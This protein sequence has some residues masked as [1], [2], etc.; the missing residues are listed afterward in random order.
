MHKYIIHSVNPDDAAS[1]ILKVIVYPVLIVNIIFIASN[2]KN[3]IAVYLCMSIEFVVHI[4]LNYICERVGWSNAKSLWIGSFRNVMITVNQIIVEYYSEKSAPT[5]LWHYSNVLSMSILY[6]VWERPVWILSVGFFK[7]TSAFGILYFVGGYPLF[8]VVSKI[9]I[10][11][12]ISLITNIM[13]YSY[14]MNQNYLKTIHVH[15]RDQNEHLKSLLSSISDFLFR[16]DKNFNIE[17]MKSDFMN[18]KAINFIGKPL[19][20]IINDKE[21]IEKSKM[22]LENV[23]STAEPASWTW[24]YQYETG[25]KRFFSAR[26]SA[27]IKDGKVVSVT[28]LSSDITDKITAEE[29]AAEA[30]RLEISS[31]AK[32]EFIS[33][34]RYMANLLF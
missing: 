3:T 17:F 5:W 31:K 26:A 15:I 7:L 10:L 19:W 24:V 33:A 21:S 9:W 6:D 23:F 13:L 22:K 18:K 16:I 34:V 29:R 4:I 25:K 12:V 14:K 11:F 28:L 1:L 30:E 27:I 20:T 2:A 8:D 32:S